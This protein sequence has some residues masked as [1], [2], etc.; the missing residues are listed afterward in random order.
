MA[1]S[2]ATAMATTAMA[3]ANVAANVAVEAEPCFGTALVP[4]LAS[5]APLDV[6]L[7]DNSSG[8]TSGG[9]TRIGMSRADMCGVTVFALHSMPHGKPED[10]PAT[11]DLTEI[12]FDRIQASAARLLGLCLV[13]V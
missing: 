5:T 2:E 1:R 12:D 3:T 6:R 13:P 9:C 8:I 7:F 4:L 11:L 10:K